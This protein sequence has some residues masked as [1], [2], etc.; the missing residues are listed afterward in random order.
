MAGQPR[1]AD[2]LTYL[3]SVGMFLVTIWAVAALTARWRARTQ[4]L[5]VI[6]GALLAVCGAWSWWQLGH[7]RNA[8]SL[9]RRAV[10]VTRNNAVAHEHLGMILAAK[11]ESEEAREQLTAAVEL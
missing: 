9:W 6:A 7:W 10:A 11:G 5:A 8:E 1:V 2:S 4:P 3:S